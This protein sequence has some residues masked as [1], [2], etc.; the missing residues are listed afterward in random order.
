MKSTYLIREFAK[1]L[2]QDEP[3]WLS[4]LLEYREKYIFKQMSNVCDIVE[5][6]KQIMLNQSIE[7]ISH[8]INIEKLNGIY[9]TE[10][11]TI[12]TDELEKVV[13]ISSHKNKIVSKY[14]SLLYV[15][16]YPVVI[17]YKLSKNSINNLT[18]LDYGNSYSLAKRL[19]PASELTKFH[20]RDIAYIIIVDKGIFNATKDKNYS[21]IKKFKKLGG[22]VVPFYDKKVNFKNTLI[23]YFSPSII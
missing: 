19:K 23:D 12:H 2:S 21:S 7:K 6:I 3:A 8:E 22:L 10:K 9:F 11:Y 17:D 1:K 13:N 15:D 14:N 4:I 16:N 20:P 5:D 18:N